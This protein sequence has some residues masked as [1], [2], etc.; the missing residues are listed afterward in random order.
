MQATID[1]ADFAAAPAGRYLAGPSWLHFCASPSLFGVVLWGR[2]GRDEVVRL[3]ESLAIEL[4]PGVARHAS[5]VD[6]SRVDSVDAAAFEL[7]SQYVRA[8]HDELS[9]HVARLALVRP[10]GMAG[11]IAA[12]FYAVLDA[13]YPVELFADAAAALAW[14]DPS[15]D[16]A[17]VADLARAQ[18]ELAE[19]APLVALL[20]AYLGE[21]LVDAEPAAAARALA[22][23]ERTLQRRLRDAG[24]TLVRELGAVRIRAAQQRMRDSAA[25]LTEIALAVGF[26]TPQHFSALFR[27][28]VGESPSAWRARHGGQPL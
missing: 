13:P 26:A 28:L 2:P 8:R 9:A 14:L 11:A 17:I 19:V 20:R 4:G 22:V 15:A 27:R 25:P 18:A 23:S 3:I 21:H 12:G 6:A 16:P 1:I 10:S 24:T 5:L 7:L